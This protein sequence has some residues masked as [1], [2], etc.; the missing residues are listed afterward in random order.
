[1]RLL[2]AVERARDE[3]PLLDIRLDWRNWTVHWEVD[4][5]RAH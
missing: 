5:F 1:M 2:S 3:C 4:C